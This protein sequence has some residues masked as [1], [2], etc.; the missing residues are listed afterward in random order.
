MDVKNAKGVLAFPYSD[1]RG[2]FSSTLEVWDVDAEE[3]FLHRG[4]IDHSS[5]LINDCADWTPGGVPFDADFFY[6]DCGY[7]PQVTRGVFIDD[8]VYSISHGGVLV[9][10]LGDLEDPVATATYGD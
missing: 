3:G 4:S 8:F 7:S 2:T 10:G 9:H 1:Y 6:Q 5:L